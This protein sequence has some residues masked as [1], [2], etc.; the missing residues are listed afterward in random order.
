MKDGGGN[1]GVGA[2]GGTGDALHDAFGTLAGALN[3]TL[4]ALGVVLPLALLGG[5]AWLVFRALLRRR[6]EAALS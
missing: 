4:R 5:L 6:R 1:N 3:L 2:L